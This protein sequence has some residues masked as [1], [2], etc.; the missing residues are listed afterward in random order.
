MGHIHI[1]YDNSTKETNFAIIKALDLFLG[2]PSLEIDLDERRRGL[3]GKAG[4]FRHKK[5]G[6][7]KKLKIF[8]VF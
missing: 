6:K 1:G 7:R 5:Y 8:L 3:Y 2:V 4:C